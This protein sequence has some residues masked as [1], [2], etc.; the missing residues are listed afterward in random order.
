MKSNFATKVFLVCG[1]LFLFFSHDK[2][3][4]KPKPLTPYTAGVVLTFDDAYVAEWVAMDKQ[5]R[6]Y[7]WKATFCVSNLNSLTLSDINGL[8]SLQNEGHEI[9]GHSLH[10]R[11]AARFVAQHGINQYLRQEVN[12]MLALMDFYGLKATAF[13]YPYGARSAA[14]DAALLKKFKILRGTVYG[15]KKPSQRN[16]YFDHSKVV[17]GFGM[18]ANYGYFSISHVLKLLEY[19]KKNKKILIIVGHKPV[20][21]ITSRY[22]TETKT[23]ALICKYVQ[24]NQMK[25]YTLSELYDLK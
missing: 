13:A 21:K 3:G 8:L 14:L 15:A 5:M 22:Q 11:N 20:K 25:F 4:H 23:V 10:H 9:A 2:E 7:S 16:F 1:M 12:P 17:Y 19:A 18:D 24:Q 6:P